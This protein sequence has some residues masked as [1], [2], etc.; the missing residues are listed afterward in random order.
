MSP[1]DVDKDPIRN[2]L[3]IIIDP[4]SEMFN[5]LHVLADPSHHLANQAWAAA[6]MGTM[7]VDLREEVAYFGQHF[8]EWLGIADVVQVI[9]PSGMNVPDF[10]EKMAQL[11]AQQLVNLSLGIITIPEYVGPPKSLDAATIAAHKAI[12]EDSAAFVK[13]LL[14]VLHRYWSEIFAVEWERRQPL[15]D[16]RRALE[17]ARLDTMEPVAWLTS[18]HDRISYEQES[19]ALV[20]HKYQDLRFVLAQLERIS[21]VPSTFIAP[22]LMVGFAGQELVIYINVSLALSLP[23]RVPPGLLDVAKA[24]AD[25]TRL[26]IY[27]SVLKQP[28]YTQELALAMGLAE[29]TVSRHLKV[30]K[31]ARLVRSSKEG[32]VVL[33]TGILDPVDR[34]PAAMRDFL[35]G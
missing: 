19:G 33:Y 3:R 17:A 23:E 24:L 29:P 31:A 34:L 30:L 7:A 28:H 27:K 13:R 2:K 18:L 14:L 32:A 35:R 10:L 12:Q 22:H 1:I 6:T 5:S 9:D 16:Q 20:F 26:R 11:P 15:L 8:D 21:C 25:E 4:V